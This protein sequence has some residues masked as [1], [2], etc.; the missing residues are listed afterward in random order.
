MKN[1]KYL[2]V[3]ALLTITLSVT[4][5]GEVATLQNGEEKVISIG[6]ENGISADAYYAEIRDSQV[7]KLVDMIDL[8]ILS[9]DYPE[10]EEETSYVES[11]I[12][13]IKLSYTDNEEQFLTDIRQYYGV[14]NEDELK[15][16][17]RLEYKRSEAVTDYI[18]K[19][20]SESEINS[21]YDEKI[22]GDIDASHILIIPDV[23]EDATADEKTAAEDE[24]KKKAEDLIKQLDDGADFAELA[25]ENSDDTGSAENGGA[26]GYFGGD[27]MD[28]SFTEAAKNLENDKYTDEPVKSQ[29]G[30]HIILKH[31]QKDKPTLEDVETDIKETLTN[32]KL[33]ESVTL[34][35]ETLMEI[36]D[37]KGVKFEDDTLKKEYDTL[38]ETILESL[39]S[40]TTY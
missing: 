4:G 30:Y 39:E 16:V 1:K 12:E 10:T 7:S 22:I 2:F 29:F 27:T 23:A 14:N 11:Q 37:E 32:D 35:Q 13:Q 40:Q 3:V 20:L 15:E 31:D 25:K 34:Y 38:M 36:R 28:E 24:A 17:F 8:E 6:E 9:E 5:C 18:E 33:N 26:L 21:Y 19:N